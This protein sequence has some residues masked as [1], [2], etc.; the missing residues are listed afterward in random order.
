MKMMTNK[1]KSISLPSG[2]RANE[3]EEMKFFYG[4]YI[5]YPKVG[6]NPKASKI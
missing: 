1:A 3:K 6:G 5:L 4:S 2:L